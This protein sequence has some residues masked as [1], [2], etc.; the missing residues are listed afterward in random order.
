MGTSELRLLVMATTLEA[1]GIRTSSQG[2]PWRTTSR[3]QEEEGEEEASESDPAADSPPPVLCSGSEAPSCDA[4]WSEEEGWWRLMYPASQLSWEAERRKG[5]RRGRSVGGRVR[6][7]PLA[8][9][10]TH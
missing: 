8:Q 6:L 2:L 7:L 3:E 5:G 10:V 4:D 1:L 9:A